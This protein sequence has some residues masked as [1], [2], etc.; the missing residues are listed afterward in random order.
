MAK[1]TGRAELIG[2]I[3]EK[4]GISKQTSTE[5]LDSIIKTIIDS[6]AQ[7]KNIK[8]PGFG[9]FSVRQKT[10]R[11]GRNPRTGQQ[12]EITA[13][14]VVTLRPSALFKEKLDSSYV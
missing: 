8:I 2:L 12:V 4:R 10:P 11:P 3:C 13:R 14:K 1:N 5:L 7:G 6:L 9:T